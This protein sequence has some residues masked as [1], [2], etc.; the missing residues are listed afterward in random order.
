MLAVRQHQASPVDVKDRMSSLDDLVHR[1][2]DPHPAETQLPEFGQG[3][4]HIVQGHIH[5]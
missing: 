1:I 2:L 3:L 4:V 5:G